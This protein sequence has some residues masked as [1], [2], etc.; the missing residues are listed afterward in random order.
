MRRPPEPNARVWSLWHG[1][2]WPVDSGTTFEA[3]VASAAKRRAFVREPLSTP[4]LIKEHGP[5]TLNASGRFVATM[6]GQH[7]GDVIEQ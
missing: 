3:M 2:W 6:K 4:A 7:P 5:I 1:R